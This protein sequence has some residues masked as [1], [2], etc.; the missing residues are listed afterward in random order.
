MRSIDRAADHGRHQPDLR[1]GRVQS[2]NLSGA[3]RAG[4][5]HEDGHVVEVEEDRIRES[6]VAHTDAPQVTG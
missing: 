1:S 5:D 2:R 3:D 4:A 6:G